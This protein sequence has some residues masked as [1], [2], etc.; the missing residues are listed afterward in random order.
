[1]IELKKKYQIH[2]KR[3]KDLTTRLMQ[4]M[5][6]MRESQRML[7][8]YHYEKREI[9][10]ANLRVGE[11]EELKSDQAILTN[12][13]QFIELLEHS[14]QILAPDNSDEGVLD[15]VRIL[16][17]NFESLER[18]DERL[19]AVKKNVIDAQFLLMEINDITRRSL[20][21]FNFDP[22]RLDE[23]NSRLSKIYE[24][25]RKYG[26]GE[27][28]ILDYLA[29]IKSEIAML[30]NIDESIQKDQDELKI[31]V[32]KSLSLAKDISRKRLEIKAYFENKVSQELEKLAMKAAVFEVRIQP[33]EQ[34]EDPESLTSDGLESVE[35][36][37]STNPGEE[38]KPLNK[39]VSGGELS[40]LMMAI[41]IALSSQKLAVTC[42]IF[43][44]IDSGIGGNTAFFIGEKLFE[45]S[46]NGQVICIT[47]LPQIACFADHH[48]VV[49]K[50][51]IDDKTKVSV[52]K[53]TDNEVIAEIV[54]MLSGEEAIAS[55]IEHARELVEVAASKKMHISNCTTVA[56]V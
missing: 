53:I 10:D 24:L 13:S 28:E 38:P 29:K 17:K 23:V 31:E 42:M 11:E 52:K 21:S 20:E 49:D 32:E 14:R 6:N 2:F 30:E 37:I 43:D 35:F 55:A 54:R 51:V 16:L 46:R 25:K 45:L 44:E 4:K 12:Y 1:M 34:P 26:D 33:V 36:Y 7:E 41:K 8:R 19:S 40:R 3:Y 56:Q 47:H 15:K 5:N 50:T 39:I 18:I 48:F 27:V 22:N 9:E